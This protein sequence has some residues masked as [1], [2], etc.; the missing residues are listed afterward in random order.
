MVSLIFR[1]VSSYCLSLYFCLLYILS[2][3][4]PPLSLSLSLSYSLTSSISFLSHFY[5]ISISRGFLVFLVS[6]SFLFRS[7]MFLPPSLSSSIAFLSL[8]LSI[9]YFSQISRLS[10]LHFFHLRSPI[11]LSFSLSLFLSL[12]LSLSLS[13]VPYLSYHSLYQLSISLRFLVSLVSIFSLKISYLSLSFSLSLSLVPY[14]SYHSLY[15]LSISLRFLVSL[16]SIFF[17]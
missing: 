4:L 3:S 17:T 6:P 15:Q 16:V 14:L 10:C 2:L 12:S 11:S 1:S 13:L 9:I 7:S 5:K 8:P